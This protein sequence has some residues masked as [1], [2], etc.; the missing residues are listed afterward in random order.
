MTKRVVPIVAA[1]PVKE[2]QRRLDPVDEMSL[3]SFPA[4]DPPGWS[5][6]RVG[7]PSQDTRAPVRRDPPS[8]DPP[9]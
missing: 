7:P 2:A 4:S 6:F 3:E 5:S 8:V 9:G 1:A